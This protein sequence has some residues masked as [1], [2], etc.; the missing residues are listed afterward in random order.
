M[1]ISGSLNES[2]KDMINAGNEAE[3][4]VEQAVEVEA[5]H[6]TKH[7]LNGLLF[8]FGLPV[9]PLKKEAVAACL[10]GKKEKKEIK[11]NKKKKMGNFWFFFSTFI[12]LIMHRSTKKAWRRRLW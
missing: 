9:D 8:Y 1:K 11:T 12:W 2:E 6:V 7:T 10:K 3:E 5:T 4:K